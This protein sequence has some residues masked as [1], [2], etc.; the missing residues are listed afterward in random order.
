MQL[1]PLCLS[2]S[3]PALVQSLD[4]HGALPLRVACQNHDSAS[5]VQY[6]LGL[7]MRTLRAVDYDNNT[8][9]HHACRGSKYDTIALLL[10]K[11]GAVSTKRNANGKLPLTSFWKGIPE[12]VMGTDMQMRS[13]SAAHPSQNGKKRKL[14]VGPRIARTGIALQYQ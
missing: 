12:M 3:N 4:N 5:V 11:H 6:L 1:P 13:T 2:R 8:A 9:L 10:D 14:G 7:D